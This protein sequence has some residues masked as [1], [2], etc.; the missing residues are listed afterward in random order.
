[1]NANSNQTKSIFITG[2]AAGIGKACAE[3]FHAAG[4]FVGLYDVDEAGCRELQEALGNERAC[5]GKLDVTEARA[6]QGALKHF[7]EASDGRLDVLFNNAGILR[8]GPFQEIDLTQQHLIVDINIKGVMNGCH[9]AFEY[10]K[11]TPGA[12]V[13][14]MASASAIYGQ[15]E[16]ATY[17]ASK[18]AVRGLT[19]ALDIEWREHGIRVVDIWPLFVQTGMMA[20]L[21]GAASAA[22]MGAKLTPGQVA[23]G[24][25]AAANKTGRFA[26]PHR[27]VGLS[28]KAFARAVKLAPDWL[29]RLIVGRIARH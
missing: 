21:D 28:A 16:I 19:E 5:V 9:T 11:Q 12:C 18:F 22:N 20:D 10:L 23:E 2:A 29:S 7:C 3:R 13:I 1:M 26:S 27:P 15:P 14:N 24:V 4:W 25:Y 8:S 6:W 17:S